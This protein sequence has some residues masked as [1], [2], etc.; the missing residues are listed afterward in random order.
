M[1]KQMPLI[2]VLLMFLAISSIVQPTQSGG[3]LSLNR[4]CDFLIEVSSNFDDARL[5]AL[6]GSIRFQTD[7]SG[8]LFRTSARMNGKAGDDR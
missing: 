8:T 3:S 4:R 7:K 6:S 1:K 2:L 5:L